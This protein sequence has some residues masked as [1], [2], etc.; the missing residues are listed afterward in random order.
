[1]TRTLAA[2]F[3]L[4]CT[5]LAQNPAPMPEFEVSDIRQNKTNEEDYARV[6]PGGEIS[7][8]N[9]PFKEI[10]S[11][12]FSSRPDLPVLGGPA[13]IATERYNITGKARPGAPDEVLQQMLKTLLIKEFKLEAHIE[14]RPAD[15]YALVAGKN[16]PKLVK[17][18]GTGKPQCRRRVGGGKDP[19]AKDMEAG[20]A[21]L[22]CTSVT[23]A[24]LATNLPRAAPTYVD[25]DVVD[26]TGIEGTYDITL[27]LTAAA[28][29]D[30]GCLT[31][32]DAVDKQLGLKLEARKLPRPVVVIDHVEKLP[33][34]N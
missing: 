3:A 28:V 10:V 4:A 31:M 18:A 6:L 2:I 5:V 32:F 16:G 7:V 9:K 20:Q 14:Q 26:L 19:A 29:I 1:M 24:D 23:M 25:H 34:D 13:W 12:A 27:N 22:V 30:Q 15:A 11:V 21:E 33:D 8:R 17:A